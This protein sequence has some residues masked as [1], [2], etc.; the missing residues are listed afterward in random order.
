MR[1]TAGLGVVIVGIAAACGRPSPSASESGRASPPT[2]RSIEVSDTAISSV[3]EVAG[4]AEPSQRATVSTKLTGSVTD[5]LVR[6]GE[7]VRHGQPLARID[8]RDLRATR[9]RLR[10]SLA[11]A[12]AVQRDAVSQARRFRSLYADSAATRVQLEAAE[13]ALMRADAAVGAARAAA[14]ELEATSAYADLRAPFS[15]VVTKR[16]VD[17]GAFVAPGSPVATVEDASRLR[18]SV[19]VTPEMAAGLTRGR[20]VSATI[21]SV[22]VDAVV[23]GVVPSAGALYTVNALVDNGRGSYASGA[24]ATLRLEQGKRR[25][26]LLPALALVREGDLTGARVETPDGSELRWIRV[27]PFADGM[28]E[29]LSGLRPG[30]RIVLPEASK[31]AR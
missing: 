5:V 7:R 28:V 13:T 20:H 11:D 16:F 30:E 1:S 14:E 21:E 8:A 12:E 26:I 27:A 2:G 17:P 23:E 3:L 25:A 31:E 24:A 15:G 29:V 19:T 6:E 10:A 9:A 4:V 22:P 18:I